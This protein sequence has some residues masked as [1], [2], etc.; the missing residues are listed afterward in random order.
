PSRDAGGLPG[1]DLADRW[2]PAVGP[3]PGGGRLEQGAVPGPG[4]ESLGHGAVAA[5]CAG[6]RRG[7]GGGEQDRRFWRPDRR[8]GR[9]GGQADRGFRRQELARR[10]EPSVPG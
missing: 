5:S 7:G 10:R 1:Q 8:Q 3:E 4:Q 9:G 2:F 6:R